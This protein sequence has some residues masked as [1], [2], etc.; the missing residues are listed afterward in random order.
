MTVLV[1]DDQIHVVD[2][3]L[4]EVDW[5]RLGIDTVW[6][7]YS[8]AE[9]RG[10]FLLNQVDIMLCD[11][12]M[13]G[14]NGLSLLKWTIDQGMETECIFLTA[15]A[16]FVYARTAMQLGSFDYILQPVRYEEVEAVLHKAAEK[17]REN[18]N[19]RQLENTR[20]LVVEQRDT[21]LDAVCM[22]LRQARNGDAEQIFSTLAEL[23]QPDFEAAGFY[24]AYIRIVRWKR[25]SNT[26]DEN[27][28]RLVIRN[29]LEE[30]LADAHG[31][32]CISSMQDN[33]FGLLAA[34][35][36]GL[37]DN[38]RWELGL[39]E[40]YDFVEAQMDFSI[41]VYMGEKLTLPAAEKLRYLAMEGGQG[42]G[43]SGVFRMD[44]DRSETKEAFR[45]A[46]PV[47]QAI[48]YIK[49]NLNKNI[50]RTDVAELVHLNEEYF[51]RLFRQQTGETFKDYI[52]IEKMNMAKTLLE[53][54][55]L[56]ISI[57]ASKVGYDNFSHFSKM[58]KKITDM[59]PQEYR[60]DRQGK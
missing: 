44:G 14:E 2:G 35:E 12:E 37:F 8:A 3:I 9:A 40:F 43:K 4:S 54:S 23:L 48:A 59:T 55:N 20:K 46:E 16:D 21:I 58:F 47:N 7:A 5:E 45:E 36:D 53:R 1:I 34:V 42:G 6:K 28:V 31:V 18:R 39:R 30:L 13:P 52:L 26:W 22:K 60:R 29:V 25:I 15:H 19:A 38:G 41:A 10:I 51:S 50:S 33:G 11:I 17:I 32:T 27:L 24:P 49:A 56:S 57:V